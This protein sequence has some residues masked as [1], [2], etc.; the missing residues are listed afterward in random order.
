MQTNNFPTPELLGQFRQFGELGPTYKIMT[1]V[2]QLD[3]QDWLLQIKIIESGEELEYKYS[4]I[5]NDPVAH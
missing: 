2:R 4:K 5:V 1:P 3:N